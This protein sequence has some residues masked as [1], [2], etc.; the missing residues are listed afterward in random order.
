M[1]LRRPVC[2]LFGS[3]F[4]E[5]EG[6]EHRGASPEEP[7]D[8]RQFRWVSQTVR[9]FELGRLLLEK[10]EA[11]ARRWMW[12]YPDIFFKT[13]PLGGGQK[14]YQGGGDATHNKMLGGRLFGTQLHGNLTLCWGCIF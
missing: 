10:H 4:D 13:F 8:N 1:T 14:L 5:W 11:Y 9:L 7:E 12:G 6:R 2:C 3:D